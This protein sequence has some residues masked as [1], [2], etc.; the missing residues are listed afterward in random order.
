MMGLGET[1][2]V[3]GLWLMAISGMWYPF[4]KRGIDRGY[5]GVR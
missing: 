1:M 3:F 2:A 5:G 4:L